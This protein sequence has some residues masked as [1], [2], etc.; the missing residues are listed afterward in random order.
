M[1]L[2]MIYIFSLGYGARTGWLIQEYAPEYG[3]RQDLC[4]LFRL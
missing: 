1:E 3:T 2:G 4:I